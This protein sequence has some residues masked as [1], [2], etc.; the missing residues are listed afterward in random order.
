MC[1]KQ[2]VKFQCDQNCG[3]QSSDRQKDRQTTHGQT[4]KVPVEIQKNG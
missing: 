3:V 2:E 4:K 1:R